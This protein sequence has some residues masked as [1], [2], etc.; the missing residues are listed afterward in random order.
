[1]STEICSPYLQIEKT[2][3][4]PP[5]LQIETSEQVAIVRALQGTEPYRATFAAD[6]KPALQFIKGDLTEVSTGVR[7]LAEAMNAKAEELWG[8][9]DFQKNYLPWKAEVDVFTGLF[10][11]ANLVTKGVM[12]SGLAMGGLSLWSFKSSKVLAVVN[13]CAAV[14]LLFFSGALER[15]TL[16]FHNFHET[17]RDLTVENRHSFSATIDRNYEAMEKSSTVLRYYFR[18]RKETLRDGDFEG[19]TLLREDLAAIKEMQI[20]PLLAIA[21]LK[22]GTPLSFHSTELINLNRIKAF[23]EKLERIFHQGEKLAALGTLVGLGCLYYAYVNRAHLMVLAG[24][25]YSLMNGVLFAAVHSYK[26]DLAKMRE[27]DESNLLDLFNRHVA[28]RL[29]PKAQDVGSL[30]QAIVIPLERILKL[31][32]V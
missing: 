8:P 30:Q 1:M 2:E 19:L 32:P 15:Y 28:G 24:L 4:R 16:A 10:P 20:Y 18:A 9:R 11:I 12:V 14:A 23:F 3:I 7:A 5:Y 13:G 22:S 27:A 17:I 26:I 31:I 21:S 6:Y 29:I 25:T